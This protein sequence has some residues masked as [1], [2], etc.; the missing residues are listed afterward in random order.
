MASSAGPQRNRP[1]TTPRNGH[2]E[3]TGRQGNGLDQDGIKR[4]QSV[5]SFWESSL[6]LDFSEKAKRYQSL[7]MRV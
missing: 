1:R 2:S 4:V 7:K 3:E 6:K 5:Q